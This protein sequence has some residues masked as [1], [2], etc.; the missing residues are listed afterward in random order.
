[1]KKNA[2][3]IKWG[4]GYSLLF[5][6]WMIAENAIG[7]HDMYIEKQTI[8]GN[9]FAIIAISTYAIAI[10]N[11]KDAYYNGT[12]TYKQGFLSGLVL[13]VVISVLSPI[14]Q[15]ITYSYITPH[16]F[17]NSIAYYIAHNIQTPEQAAAYFNLKSFTIQSSF[18]NLSLGVITATVVAYFIKN[19]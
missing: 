9:L 19:K 5:L 1:M 15:F 13:S 2:I 7:L 4:I 17:D 10:K 18:G 3:E 11:K 8:Y 6:V 16:F 14:V 12:I